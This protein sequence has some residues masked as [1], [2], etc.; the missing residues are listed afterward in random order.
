[1]QPV[2]Q[3]LCKEVSEIHQAWSAVV[4]EKQGA[5]NNVKVNFCSLTVSPCFSRF[6]KEN[7]GE[8]GGNAKDARIRDSKGGC[9]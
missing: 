3:H 9:L 1:M 8:V 4:K 5:E 6:K 2:M 7:A